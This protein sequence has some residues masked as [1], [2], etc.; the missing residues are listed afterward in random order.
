MDKHQSTEHF[1]F[2]IQNTKDTKC[3]IAKIKP[4]KYWSTSECLLRKRS[5][6]IVVLLRGAQTK[7]ELLK[8]FKHMASMMSKKLHTETA[9]LLK[10]LKQ[11]PRAAQTVFQNTVLSSCNTITCCSMHSSICWR[12]GGS[13]RGKRKILVNQPSLFYEKSQQRHQTYEVDRKSSF[14]L[15]HLHS[16]CF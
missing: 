12:G 9:F 14:A 16:K 10:R 2:P 6:I 7:T 15:P 5:S 11:K 3:G 4:L 8:A 1:I 13:F